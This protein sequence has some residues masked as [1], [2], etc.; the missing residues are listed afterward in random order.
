MKTRTLT[1]SY[2]TQRGVTSPFLRLRGKWLAKAGFHC[3]DKMSVQVI[4]PG[5]LVIKKIEGR[6]ERSKYA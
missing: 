3:Q 2:I 1:I 4:E 5:H 6:E